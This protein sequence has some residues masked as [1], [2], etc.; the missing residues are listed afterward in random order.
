MLC[1]D[2]EYGEIWVDFEACVKSFYGSKDAFD[3]EALRRRRTLEDPSVRI[4]P[5]RRSGLPT[6]RQSADWSWGAQVDMQVLFVL[7]NIGETL[8]STDSATSP[9]TLRCPSR[10]AIVTLYPVDGESPP[11]LSSL[12]LGWLR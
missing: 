12:L 3:A 2:G 10:N 9:W 8:R 11:F 4:R 7:G 6:Q 1:N 5:H